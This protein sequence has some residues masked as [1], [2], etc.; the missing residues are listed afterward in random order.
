MMA[1]IGQS[2]PKNVVWMKI[3][4]KASNVEDRDPELRKRQ[5]QAMIVGYALAWSSRAQHP[6]FQ[7]TN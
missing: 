4:E 7:K 1:R 5:A 6:S 2:V 3:A